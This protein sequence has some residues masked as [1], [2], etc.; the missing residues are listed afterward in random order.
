MA[1]TKHVGLAWQHRGLV[2]T[3][4]GEGKVPITIDGE[5]AEGPGPMESLLLALA[6]C[7]GSDVVVVM[8]KKR[9][10]LRELRIEVSGERR[11]E[12]PQRYVAI[13]LTYSVTAPGATEEQVRHAIDLS[14]AKY[15]SVTHSL[16]P[17]IAIRYELVLQA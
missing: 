8:R 7:T 1:N 11:E 15:C 17:A 16:N 3:G 5:N 13:D 10:D 4:E 14:L 2:F 9:L 12:H 6:A